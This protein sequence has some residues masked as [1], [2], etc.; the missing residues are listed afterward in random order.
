MD[1]SLRRPAE[2]AVK[3]C[4]G[5]RPEESCLVVTDDE[6]KAI[7]EALYIIA[8]ETTGD[9]ATIRYPVGDQHGAE[10][11]E[12]VPTAMTGADVV[13]APTTK[14]LSHT[15]ARIEA[16]DARVGGAAPEDGSLVACFTPDEAAVCIGHLVS[17]VDASSG[18]VVELERVLV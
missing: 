4:M 6:R 7:A 13:L 1:S 10:P 17:D 15:T 9:V 5:L 2:T 16:T 8:G 12:P 3:Q 11:P 14:S 18:I